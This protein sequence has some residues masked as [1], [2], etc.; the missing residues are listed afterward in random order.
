MPVFRK[1]RSLPFQ[2]LVSIGT[3]VLSSGICY[4]VSDYL[5]YRSVALLLLFVV[6]LLSILL[7]VIPILVAAVLSALIW[8][9]FFIPPHFTFH[10]DN[11]E[12]G[13]MLL[14]YFIIAL[15]NGVLTTRI[16]K[17]EAQSKEKE[18]KLKSL[19]LYNTVFNSLAH[20]LRTPIST[21][22]GSTDNLLNN[23]ENLSD[24]NRDKLI[25]EIYRATER[26]NRLV[27]NLLN[28]S[29]LDTGHITIK[30]DWC[31]INELVHSV[32]NSLDEDLKKHKLVF[33][34]DEHLPLVKVDYGLIEQVVFNIVH[35][36][37][38]YTE[39][40][41]SII[42]ESEFRN[43]SLYLKV[44]DNGKGIPE[45][46]TLKVFDKFYSIKG[47][48]SKG[49]GLGLSIAKGFVEAH[50]GRIS[51]YNN[52]NQGLTIEIVLPLGQNESMNINT[53]KNE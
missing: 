28:I 14:M 47:R 43:S 40:G 5:G 18:E 10:V 16:R 7:D 22:Y 31:N 41:S 24:E 13:L 4:L 52:T 32:V 12:D 33:N 34:I 6:S 1:I 17:I 3:I 37:S 51:A 26:L 29:R 11:P 50:N 35:N 42:I 39:E 8:D 25:N 45:D 30:K 49:T 44:S 36:A 27:G 2:Y 38:A 20:E 15:V 9:F 53:I 46:E 21:I 19:K 23:K 48:S